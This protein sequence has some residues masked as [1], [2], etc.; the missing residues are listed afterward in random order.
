MKHQMLTLLLVSLRTLLLLACIGYNMCIMVEGCNQL[1]HAL[2]HTDSFKL[3]QLFS[4]NYFFVGK[5]RKTRTTE[6]VKM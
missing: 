6:Q 2:K 1:L 4:N 3:Q 5:L